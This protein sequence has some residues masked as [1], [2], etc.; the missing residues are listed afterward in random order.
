LVLLLYRF[1]VLTI[2]RPKQELLV[3]H[4]YVFLKTISTFGETL[5]AHSLALPELDLAGAGI[6]KAPT[7]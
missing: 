1:N 5:W 7:Q 4:G 6:E 3:K 2:E